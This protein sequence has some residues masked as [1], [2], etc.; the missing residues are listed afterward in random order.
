MTSNDEYRILEPEGLTAEEVLR[1]DRDYKLP[2]PD[3]DREKL[4]SR[5]RRQRL[6][7]ISIAEVMVATTAICLIFALSNW[8]RLDV[9]SA[10]LGVVAFAAAMFARFAKLNSRLTMLV[11]FTLI[12]GYL[13]SMVAAVAYRN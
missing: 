5:F 2:L 8:F 10:I 13:F 3:E 11:L 4:E 1:S 6:K 9:F 7:R 12:C